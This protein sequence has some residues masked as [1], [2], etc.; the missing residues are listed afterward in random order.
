[1]KRRERRA[2][3]VRRMTRSVCG[4]RRVACSPAPFRCAPAVRTSAGTVLPPPLHPP[5]VWRS[6]RL[7]PSPPPAPAGGSPAAATATAWRGASTPPVGPWRPERPACGGGRGARTGLPAPSRL[8]LGAVGRGGGPRF[9]A[10]ARRSPSR[11][12]PAP[13]RRRLPAAPARRGGRPRRWRGRCGYGSCTAVAA[14]VTG[15]GNSGQTGGGAG[16]T[17]PLL[18]RRVLGARWGGWAPR[19]SG[20]GGRGYNQDKDNKRAHAETQPSSD[21]QHADASCHFSRRRL[22]ISRWVTRPV[23]MDDESSASRRVWICGAEWATSKIH[24]HA[25]Y[26]IALIEYLLCGLHVS[27]GCLRAVSRAACRRYSS[28]VVSVWFGLPNMNG[29]QPDSLE[30]WSVQIERNM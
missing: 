13:A 28:R 18:V 4:G 26:S 19:W 24:V 20:G 8:P 16:G 3:T 23:S 30:R 12:P 10:A 21:N 5:S 11:R 15:Y 6:Y 17:G 2:G 7:G 25:S 22:R 1:M 29:I 27:I 9:S 14:A